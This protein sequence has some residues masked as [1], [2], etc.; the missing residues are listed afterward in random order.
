[1]NNKIQLKLINNGNGL[2]LFRIFFL[3]KIINYYSMSINNILYNELIKSGLNII[4][5]KLDDKFSICFFN[6]K[7]D[8][9]IC[10]LYLKIIKK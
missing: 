1:M 2:L 7:Q 6:L 8:I 9:G 10:G 3:G 4:N 5:V